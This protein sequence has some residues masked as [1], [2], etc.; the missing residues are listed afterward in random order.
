MTFFQNSSYLFYPC[1]SPIFDDL[2]RI[3]TLLELN[4]L[5]LLLHRTKKRLC[6]MTRHCFSIFLFFYVISWDA[7]SLSCFS[8]CLKRA[9]LFFARRWTRSS[10]WTVTRLLLLLWRSS[11]SSL[12]FRR[13]RGWRRRGWRRSCWRFFFVWGGSRGWRWRC[14]SLLLFL[15]RSALLTF[16]IVTWL[17]KGMKS[18]KN[19]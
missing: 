9:T 13:R 1:E 5:L 10:L 16:L 3:T 11:G 6:L 12:L 17:M 14:S 7:W 19:F 4:L 15:L 8:C 2:F 18:Q